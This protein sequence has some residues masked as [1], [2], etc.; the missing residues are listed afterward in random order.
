MVLQNDRDC[1]V[2]RQPAATCATR[3]CWCSATRRTTRRPRRARRSG[4]CAPVFGGR[5]RLRA[6]PLHGRWPR[7]A[8]GR[9]SRRCSTAGRSRRRTQA[10][11]TTATTG[12]AVSTAATASGRVRE[13]RA[14]RTSCGTSSRAMRAPSRRPTTARESRCA[15]T[16]RCAN[17]HHLGVND[18]GA[19]DFRTA[20][21]GTSG[22]PRLEPAQ[23]AELGR[24]PLL[25]LQGQPAHRFWFQFRP[26]GI[27]SLE[28]HRLDLRG[29]LRTGGIAEMLEAQHC[30]SGC[31]DLFR[32]VDQAR[33]PTVLDK[34]G[35]DLRRVLSA[36]D[37]QARFEEMGLVAAPTTPTS[38]SDS[39]PAR[40]RAGRKLSKTQGSRL[41]RGRRTFCLDYLG[42]QNAFP[43]RRGI[44][45]VLVD[46]GPLR[47]V[48][49]HLR[50]QEEPP[51][52]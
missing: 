38:F 36:P 41:N 29:Q 6:H 45:T 42:D 49:N 16:T 23:H 2:L 11:P 4:A 12:S 47:G 15:A 33:P 34:L 51:A 39:W 35:S 40:I 28:T 5:L 9:W 17:D 19:Y 44:V 10:T 14:I 18:P 48:P 27:Q 32:V 25:V 52:S 3:I 20:G 50:R 21:T 1:T 43:T 24:K 7:R 26:F 31:G 8:A 22:S 13:V 46:A 30:P 37:V